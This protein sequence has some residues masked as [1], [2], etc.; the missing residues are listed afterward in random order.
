MA[1]FWVVAQYV[2]KLLPDYTAL[3]PRRQPTFILPLQDVF[4]VILPSMNRSHSR[5]VSDQNGEFR[6]MIHSIR[7]TCPSHFILTDLITL[8][9]LGDECIIMKLSLCSN[10]IVI[11]TNS[12]CFSISA[13]FL[14]RA[15][16][17][18]KRIFT[19][20]MSVTQGVGFVTIT[21]TKP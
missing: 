19:A 6:P 3:Q 18:S 14:N 5:R 21:L 15:P 2:G 10:V 9:I 8:T 17:I 11:E 13:R 20:C 1:V 7:A 16:C 12:D 4:N